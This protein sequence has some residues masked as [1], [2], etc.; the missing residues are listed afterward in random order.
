LPSVSVSPTSATIISGNSQSLTAANASSY[1]WSPSTG[2]SSSSGT[3][4]SASPT[5]TTTYTVTGTDANGCTNTATSTITILSSLAGGTISGNQTIC[6]GNDPTAFTNSTSASGGTGSLT[7]QWQKSTN[8]GSTW[9]DISSATSSTFDETST[10]AVTTSYRR[11]VTDGSAAVEY[12][13]TL[14]ITVNSKPDISLSTGNVGCFGGNNGSINTT[15]TS[16]TSPFTYGWTASS[17][18]AST[19]DISS[20]TAKTY[21]L[22]VTDNNSCKDTASSTVTEPAAA[23]SLSN[24]SQTNVLCFGNTTGSVTVSASGGTSPYEYKIG[25][26]SYSSSATFSTLAAGSYTITAKDANGCTQTL[27]VTITQPSA[28]ISVTSVVSTN[29]S[30]NAGTD[31]TITITATGGSTKKYSIDHCNRR[32]YQEV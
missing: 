2:L 23:L 13:N 10:I 26:G 6:F 31:G 32:I 28:A 18:T 21:T 27:S 5:S 14:T 16:G 22:I 1:S 7:L 12:S 25:S 15:I 30:C 4:V 19:K 17:F 24:S 11:K 29:I 9:S 3:T 8:G 20:L